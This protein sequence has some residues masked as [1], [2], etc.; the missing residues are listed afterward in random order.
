MTVAIKGMDMPTS[1]RNC[2]LGCRKFLRLSLGIRTGAKY[3]NGILPDCPLI[4]LPEEN[5]D[6]SWEELVEKFRNYNK[7]YIPSDISFIR[8]Y[9]ICFNSNG[10]IFFLNDKI[11]NR[12][13]YQMYQ[14]IKALIGETK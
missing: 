7:I 14:I 2:E 12:T 11:L 3:S 5:K 1:C 6:M 10:D 8:L 13:P 9:Q 4:E